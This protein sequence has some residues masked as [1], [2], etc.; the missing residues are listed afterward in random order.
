[1]S[2]ARAIQRLAMQITL[3]V[4]VLALGVGTLGALEVSPEHR[5]MSATGGL[6]IALLISSLA[7]SP[8]AVLLAPKRA[9]GSVA[10]RR[11]RRWLGLS[12]ALAALTHA[13]AGAYGYL[14]RIALDPI[15]GVPW[16]R[17]GALALVLLGALSLTSFP[18]VTRALH[19]RAWSALHRLVYPAALLAALHATAAPFGD[20]SG[21][22]FA[23]FLVVALLLARPIA[24]AI[25][26]RR[27]PSA[28]EP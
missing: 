23:L 25:V 8:V 26:S 27:R 2:D 18:A 11:A 21:G 15:F 3:T 24:R 1:M 12:A 28:I 9:M 17:H 14:G 6:A 5:L 19:V 7:C 20:V 4:V 16:L 22:A 10:L 13:T